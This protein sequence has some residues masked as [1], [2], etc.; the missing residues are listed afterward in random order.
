[1]LDVR[2]TVLVAGRPAR[3]TVRLANDGPALEAVTVEVRV[4][5]AA[6]AAAAGDVAAGAVRDVGVAGLDAPAAPGRHR[7]AVVVRAGGRLVAAARRPV[8]VVPR[9]RAA[10]AVRVAGEGA[11]AEALAAAGTEV[12]AAGVLV[13]AED[14]LDAHAAR[15]A[16]ALAG[17][18]GLV[19]LAQPA[20]AARHFPVPVTLGPPPAGGRRTT[21]SGALPCLPRHADLGGDDAGLPVDAVVT[22]RLEH[23]MVL[24]GDATV[25]GA[26][27]GLV[28]CQ[29]RLASAAAAGHPLAAALLADLVRWAAAPRAAMAVE[30]EAKDDGRRLAYY[31]FPGWAQ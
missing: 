6:A 11:T 13:V 22:G 5:E 25:V 15:A 27:G 9:P 8:L 29:Y 20:A 23:P 30:V 4:G 2:D 28:F 16:A 26:H 14:A 17:G 10:V 1:M 12:G 21:P 7:A 19:V 24:A 3:A 31:S 18:D